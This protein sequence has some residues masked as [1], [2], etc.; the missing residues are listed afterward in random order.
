MSDEKGISIE[1]I[2]A[3]RKAWEEKEGLKSSVIEAE[4]KKRGYHTVRLN[5]D[6]I[7]IT[8]D[9]KPLLFRDMN[10]PLSSSAM[11]VLIDDKH[12]SRVLVKQAGLSVPES[13]DSRLR[14]ED[15]FIAFAERVGYPIVLKPNNLSRGMGVF[16]NI[17]D[18]EDLRNKLRKLADLI[19]T[20]T[21]KVLIEKQFIGEDYRFFVVD[22]EVIACT[23]RARANVVG[24]GK[25]S[26]R[27]L[28]DEKNKG[29]MR[30]RAM[31]DYPIP[32]D[33]KSLNRLAPQGLTLED[34]PE[35][36]VKVVLRDESNI[37]NGGESID[38]TKTCHPGFKDIARQSIKAIPGLRY[39]GLD[40]I[41]KDITQAPTEDN[42]VLTEIEFSP[43]PV[44]MFPWIGEPIDM[45][46]PI[47]DLY[48]KELD[49]L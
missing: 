10:G 44:S 14:L 40:I 13:Q 9:N 48:V 36:G 22:D 32:T 17:F 39:A 6:T 20:D 26:I 33:S 43:G 37:A 49:C 11:N 5:F 31:K 42:Y 19:G 41:A 18:E 8:I 38:F 12:L 34:V 28:I 23:K 30:N 46:G 27:Q 21:E 35:K 7:I 15:Q 4:A 3:N 2:E 1:E 47:L 25:Q 29:R 24:D 16:T 45:A